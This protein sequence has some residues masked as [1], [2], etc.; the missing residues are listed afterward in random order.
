MSLPSDHNKNIL[1]KKGLIPTIKQKANAVIIALFTWNR[2]I[3]PCNSICIPSLVSIS[4]S[5][6]TPKEIIQ[7]ER[8]GS[9]PLTKQI[10]Y[11]YVE[12]RLY[13]KLTYSDNFKWVNH[14]LSWPIY[15]TDLTN[16]SNFY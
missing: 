5:P 11:M 8:I 1:G 13:C 7:Y 12:I 6:N 10:I 4:K 14:D 9:L 15:I 3:C 16:Q 2:P